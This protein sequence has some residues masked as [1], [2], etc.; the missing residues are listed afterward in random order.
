MHT[1]LFLV[2][3]LTIVVLRISYT[4]Y[5]LVLFINPLEAITPTPVI[6]ESKAKLS[7]LE[8]ALDPSP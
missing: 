1:N 8:S 5:R 4:L 3:K 2:R 7:A 6:K